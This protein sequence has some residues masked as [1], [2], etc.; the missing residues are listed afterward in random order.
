MSIRSFLIVL[1]A[2]AGLLIAAITAFATFVIIDTPIGMKMFS[3]IVLNVL[4]VLPFVMLIS[5]FLGRY[6]TS[7]FSSVQTRLASVQSETFTPHTKPEFLHE[8]NAVH[9]DID[10]LSQRLEEL[11]GTLQSQNQTL[12]NMLVTL[13]HDIKTPLAI[14]RGHIEE[15][16]DGMVPLKQLQNVY[17]KVQK[18]IDF[19]DEITIAMLTFLDSSTQPKQS[20]ALKVHNFI[21]S[22]VLSLLPQSN[23]SYHNEIPQD[24]TMRFYPTDLKQILLNLLENAQKYAISDEI[25]LFEHAGALCIE[26]KAHPI[27]DAL[28]EKIFEP[29]FT[30]SSSKNRKESGF[31]LGLSIV[32]NLARRNGYE[33]RVSQH[34]DF[35]CFTLEAVEI[36]C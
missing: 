26:H 21:A 19:L 4:A 35:I 25:R 28:H 20:E 17:A 23:K 3:K 32:R 14:M 22:E 24:F 9:H 12:N 13:S 11:I 5:Y 1:Y 29:F 6:F 34:S 2:A 27:A 36:G 33:C 16:E 31:G 30:L 8:I 10:H 7:I 15:L 18:E